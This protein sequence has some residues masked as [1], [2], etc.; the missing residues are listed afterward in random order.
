MDVNAL[1]RVQS[2]PALFVSKITDEI[3]SKILSREELGETIQINGIIFKIADVLNAS[4]KIP[5]DVI[6]YLARRN[7]SGDLSMLTALEGLSDVGKQILGIL[8]ESTALIL[9]YM[10]NGGSLPVLAGIPD[11]DPDIGNEYTLE[12]IGDLFETFFNIDAVNTLLSME[13]SLMLPLTGHYKSLADRFAQIISSEE[14]FI[15]NYKTYRA[16]LVQ[17]IDTILSRSRRES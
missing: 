8:K 12:M 5:F 11:A 15:R 16:D 6:R 14:S 9:E 2:N 3:G 7:I 1:E 4:P 10:G 17:A 13:Y